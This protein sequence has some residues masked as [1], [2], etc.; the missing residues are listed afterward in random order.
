MNLGGVSVLQRAD[1]HMHTIYSDG[2]L[3][4]D[5]LARRAKRAGL[6]VI[7][8][9]D[10]D[11]VA[12]LKEATITGEEVELEVIPGVELSVSVDD[13]D[14]HILAY[15]V[16]AQNEELL[17]YLA[18]MRLERLKRAERIVEKLHAINIPLKMEKVLEKAGQGA[19]GRPHIA[20]A[21][22]EEGLAVSY[23][24]VFLK[25]IGFGRPA[26]VGKYQYSPEEAIELIGRVGGLSFVAH[27]GNSLPENI[28]LRIIKAGID[29]IETVHPSH[30]P[31]IVAH[32]QAIANEYY[33]LES[34]GSDF[35]GGK[36][37]DDAS[38]GHF[39]VPLSAV[40]AMRRRLFAGQN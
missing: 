30:S 24:D 27:P 16:D 23:H 11:N 33:L 9:T 34:G 39:G 28:M 18:F 6:D 4:P 3:S 26:Y 36:K 12:G 20:S 13:R 19:V 21:L 2:V 37:N 40:E 8:I 38:L 14:I 10:H 22:V 25:Y 15:F 29:G 1:L 32:Y 35:H 5:E 7:S 31:E 17:D